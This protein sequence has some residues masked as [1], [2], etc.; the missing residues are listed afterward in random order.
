MTI[1]V[2]GNLDI[3]GVSG[4]TV[5]WTNVDLDFDGGGGTYDA[6]WCEV[7][8]STV[9]GGTVD[10]TTN[11]IDNGGNDG[12][13]FAAAGTTYER[14][15]SSQA[16]LSDG[17]DRL[18]EALRGILSSVILSDGVGRELSLER[19]LASQA[20]VFDS[21]ISGGA[22]TLRYAVYLATDPNPTAGADLISGSTWATAYAVTLASETAPTVATVDHVGPE[23]TGLT[24]GTNYKYAVVDDDAGTYSGLAFSGSITTSGAAGTTYERTLSSQTPLSDGSDRLTEALRNLFSSA[25]I[26]DGLISEAAATLAKILRDSITISDSALRWTLAERVLADHPELSDAIAAEATGAT[27]LSVILRDAVDPVDGALQEAWAERVLASAAALSDDLS[28]LIIAAGS[29]TNITLSDSL[30]VADG[31]DAT[32]LIE[33]V[34]YDAAAAVDT[35]T[36]DAAFERLLS[37]DAVVYDALRKTSTGIIIKTLVSRLDV[38]DTIAAAIIGALDDLGAVEFLLRREPIVFKVEKVNE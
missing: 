20:A 13:E 5:T 16:S 33:R 7:S 32:R 11:C 1:T 21:L 28:A 14:T 2:Q 37:T 29:E 17:S 25:M 22:T 36:R 38:N 27:L 6:D 35:L 23:L 9:T 4:N 15:L 26:S 34:I 24:A 30:E 31:F 10:A 3:N 18:T 19:L 12:W 8:G